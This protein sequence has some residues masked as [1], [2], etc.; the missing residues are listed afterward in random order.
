MHHLVD[1]SLELGLDFPRTHKP[2]A[3][4]PETLLV[5]DGFLANLVKQRVPDGETMKKM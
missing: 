4:R 5:R 3:V 1:D 2:F